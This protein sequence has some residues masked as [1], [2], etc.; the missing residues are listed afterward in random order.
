VSS[1]AHATLAEGPADT[2]RVAIAPISLRL[3]PVG[4]DR[5]SAF[6]HDVVGW[7][8]LGRVIASS[9][10]DQVAPSPKTWPRTAES[11]GRR[12]ATRSAQLVAFESARHGL[13]AALDR[14][15]EYVRCGCESPAR[16]VGQVLL[17][18]VTDH[19][20]EGRRRVGWPRLA[21]A[22]AGAYVLGRL[23]PT[24]GSL[25]TVT[26]RALSTVG[27]SVLGHA[28]REFGL[29]PAAAPPPAPSADSA[30]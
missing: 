9:G 8:A 29:L 26:V 1:F 28:A 18:T 12:F 13:A 23:Q 10:T 15:T 14:Q 24:Q 3:A 17:G 22:L 21:G 6:R 19:D 20:L 16:R 30:P 7:S 2:P 27:L 5:W 4:A 11:Y 25:S